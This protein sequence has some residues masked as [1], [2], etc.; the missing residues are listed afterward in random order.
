MQDYKLRKL[1][2]KPTLA[3]T[4]N[5]HTCKLRRDLHKSLITSKKLSFEQWLTIFEDAA[6]LG[7][8]RLDISGGEP[9][10]Y[11]KLI[12][13]IKAG[14]QYGWYVNVNTNGS[15]INEEYAERLVTSGLDAVSISIYSADP[16]IHD[17]MRN[18]DGLWQ[19]ATRAVRIF[20]RLNKKYPH[21][22]IATQCLICRENY[23]SLADLIKL[24]Y[25]LGSDRVA[26][27]Y[28]EGDFGKKYLLDENEIHYF[29]QAVVPEI[30]A[31]CETL[32]PTVSKDAIRVAESLYSEQINSVSN[33][34][35]GLY[36]PRESNLSPCQRPTNFT[37]LLANGD[38]HP[39]NMVEYSHE[40]VM[41]NLFER[42]LP[43][44]WYSEKWN[45]FRESLFDYC[46]WCPINLYT[47]IPLKPKE[48]KR[49]VFS[50]PQNQEAKRPFA[51]NEDK[52]LLD[53]YLNGK[54]LEHTMTSVKEAVNKDITSK[55]KVSVLLAVYNC[56][57]FI[58]Q[59]LKSIY[60]QT[61]QDFEVVIVDDGS[62]DKTSEI[63]HDMK[64]SRTSIHTNSENK[65]LATSLNIGLNFCTGQYIARMD[66]DDISLPQ[67][68]EKQVR[69]LDENPNCAALGSW[70]IRIDSNN[71]II[72]NWRHPTEFEG[73]KK[74]LLE[75]NSIFHGTAMVR[76]H[77]LMEIGGYNEKY[78]YSQDYD[79]WIRLSETAK[80]Q[81]LG[82]FLYLLR[83]SP[84]SVSSIKK[85]QQD[86]YAEL[87]RQEALQRISTSKLGMTS[88]TSL[89]EN[90][91]EK[92]FGEPASDYFLKAWE[93]LNRENF[94]KAVE[95][96]QKYRAMMDYS[97]LSRI[98][99][100][101]SKCDDIDVSVIIVTYNRTEYLKKN[102]ESLSKQDDTNF[103]VIVVDNGR[104][105]FEVCPQ[106][107]DQYVKCPINFILSE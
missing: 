7:V 102:L 64:D 36:R 107:A 22:L 91:D 49:F 38:V 39:C 6:K 79:L 32:D 56:E 52:E 101:E 23:R 8:E 27:T 69:Y 88:K 24:D 19:K 77:S 44:I 85:E 47:T 104:S 95:Y 68:F 40:P 92:H 67:R 80:I 11:K 34:A 103:E 78:R 43:E 89:S 59:A 21:F 58:D 81:N 28:L 45:Q 15:L 2:I 18:S 73:I 42:N 74:R 66:A 96:M 17:R 86:T 54:S 62:T 105:G 83:S 90:V 16:Q 51:V 94:E 3:C 84:E 35:K 87:A 97:T 106:Y 53:Q 4:A 82:E 63:L 100:K 37:K 65:G 20:S 12:D 61:Y 99:N 76:R 50:S 70:C 57:K 10:L 14:K 30:K 13:L 1:V 93:E 33:F 46:R 5:C 9:T 25:E 71:K 26:L 48:K 72:S 31:F 98:L 41:G 75:E 55:P 29:R 60:D